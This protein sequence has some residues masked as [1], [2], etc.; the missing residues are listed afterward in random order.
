M[1]TSSGPGST[2]SPPDIELDDELINGFSVF[3]RS[4]TITVGPI[5]IQNIGQQQGLDVEFTVKKT[6]KAKE[7]NTCDLKIY[8]LSA[9]S[10]NQ[11]GMAAQTSTVIQAP[12]SGLSGQVTGN[13]V[14]IIPVQIDAG[15]VGNTSTIFLG[16]MCS[17]QSVTDGPDIVTELNT[18]D[19]KT[20]LQL[21]R[22][23]QSFMQGTTPVQ[24][25][26]A[27]LSAMGLT[28][29]GNFA[30]VQNLFTSAPSPLFQRGMV[31]KGN[32]A[33]MLA[34]ICF[35]VGVE[36]S[37]QNGQAQFLSNGQPYAGEAY[38]LTPNTGLV[39]TPTVDTAGILSCMSF[40]FPGIVPGGPIA[41]QSVFVNG[42]YRILSVEYTG[43][44]WGN[45]WFCKIEAGAYGVAP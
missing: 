18:G 43:S 24:V 22:I 5:Q 29:T 26:T 33:R 11:L 39:G 38:L 14:K 45:E 36:F 30:S 23:N 40:I 1:N 10:L 2:N 31:M 25:V 13:P 8:N 37:I 28:G 42:T 3:D 15:Y 12:P 34:D 41:V 7:A 20:A 19:G 21:Q 27:L 32:P 6:L 17:A 4:C 16:E 9:A 44:T 35:G